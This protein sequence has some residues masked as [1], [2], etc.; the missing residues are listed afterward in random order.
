MVDQSWMLALES[1]RVQNSQVDKRLGHTKNQ[2]TPRDSFHPIAKDTRLPKAN[3]LFLIP[4]DSILERAS[5]GD[6]LRDGQF[7]PTE[8][9]IQVSE[10]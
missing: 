4:S 8:D 6:Y 9:T 1:S 10:S 7:Y 5:G 3:I 2:H